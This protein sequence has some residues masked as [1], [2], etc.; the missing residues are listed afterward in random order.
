MSKFRARAAFVATVATFGAAAAVPG[1]ASAEVTSNVVGNTVTISSDARADNFRIVVDAGEI[2]FRV[3]AATTRTGLANGATTTVVV[4]GGGGNDIIDATALVA[5]DAASLTINGGSED[6][7]LTGGGGADTLNG[8]DGNDRVVGFTGGDVMNGNLGNDVLVW[9]NG[10]GSDT[11]VG[12]GG[13]DVLEVNGSANGDD[14]FTI[15]PSGLDGHVQFN[16]ISL[17]G[18][19]AGNFGIDADGVQKLVVNGLGGNDRATGFDGIASV[20][21]AGL[22]LNGGAGADA[23]TGGDTN[24][25]I[26]GGDGDDTLNGGNG[27]DRLVGDRGV[28]VHNGGNGDDTLVWNNGDGKDVDNGDAGLDVTEVNGGNGADVFTIVPNGARTQFDRTNVGAFS[29]DMDTEAVQLNALNGDDSLTVAP[30]LAGRIAVNANGGAGNDAFTGAEEIDSF[31]GGSGNDRLTG[32]GGFDLL[33]GQE[34]DDALFSRDSGGDLVR[35]GAG[36]DSAQT[37]AVQVDAITAVEALDATVLPGPAPVGDIRAFAPSFGTS[38]ITR[39]GSK[40]TLLV[41]VTCPAAEAG[42]C[43]ATVSVA[44]SGAV[45]LGGSKVVAVLGSGRVTLAKGQTKV[46]TIR[47]NAAAAKLVKGGKLGLRLSAVS[48]DAAGNQASSSKVAKVGVPKAKKAKK[49]K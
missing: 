23:L 44:T 16:R 7:L 17:N 43:K 18:A 26:T 13:N 5:A 6:D 32:G 48:S 22:E 46:V 27:A 12:G 38:K 10:D 19:P 2:A 3:G 11:A 1:V 21:S 35:G 33:D 30:G 20:L 9:N 8:G 15:T 34:G 45:R 36:T 37:D 14:E 42:G 4:N 29:L 40:L 47:L 28:D 41:P 49:K 24:D 31:F 39:K 25:L